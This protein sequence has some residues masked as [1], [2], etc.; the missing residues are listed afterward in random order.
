MKPLDPQ[1]AIWLA[2]GE[3]L[4]MLLR[5]LHRWLRAGVVRLR[6]RGLAHGLR[7]IGPARRRP[8]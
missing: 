6:T 4:G 7:A 5:L 8:G 3:A 2:R 1:Q